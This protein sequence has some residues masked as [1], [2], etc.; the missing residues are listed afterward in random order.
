MAKIAHVSRDL[1]SLIS[2]IIDGHTS[3]V[4]FA[5][6]GVA[7]GKLTSGDVN[8]ANTSSFLSGLYS[9]VGG[10]AGMMGKK[11]PVV[12]QVAVGSA[13]LQIRDDLKK[14]K[15]KDSSLSNLASAITGIGGAKLLAAAGPAA[16]AV[17]VGLLNSGLWR[18]GGNDIF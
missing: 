10:I 17:G 8:L 9:G 1:N 3:P 14:G 12:S 5:G 15:I 11:L 16:L 18:S 6:A 7:A 13:V 4:A 2:G